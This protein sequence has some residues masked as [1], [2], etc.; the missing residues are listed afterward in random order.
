MSEVWLRSDKAFANA[1]VPKELVAQPM[2][3]KPWRQWGLDLAGSSVLLSTSC[4]QSLKRIHAGVLWQWSSEGWKFSLQ[5]EIWSL[6]FLQFH[7]FLQFLLFLEF[8][9]FLVAKSNSIRGFVRL[10][11]RGLVR[12]SHVSQKPQIKVNSRKFKKIHD[13]SQLLAEWRP[14][15]S[16]F[17]FCS[18]C[19][20]CSFCSF[21]SL[22][23]YH[24]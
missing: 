7:Q 5:S 3:G 14:C 9:Q 2:A 24:F 22:S 11:V 23:F 4:P 13:F 8:L 20:L 10:W 6:Q 16:F 21:C 1:T 19:N 18:F 15:C 12:W 17:S